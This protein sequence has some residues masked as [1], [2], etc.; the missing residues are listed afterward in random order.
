ML[1]KI[2]T[3]QREMDGVTNERRTLPIE[4]KVA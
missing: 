1:E 4:R 3:E 2:T